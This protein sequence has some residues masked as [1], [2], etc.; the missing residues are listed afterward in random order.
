MNISKQLFK[1]AKTPLGDLIVGISFDT[2]LNKLLPVKRIK[3]TDKVLA[4]WHP[5][6]Y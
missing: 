1:L 5:K 3:E 6:P 4:F 2:P